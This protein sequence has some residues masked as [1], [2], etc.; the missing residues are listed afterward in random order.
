[1]TTIEQSNYLPELAARIRA[2][3]QA[4]AAALRTS[5]EHGIA[6]GADTL[7]FLSV[8]GMYRAMGYPGRDAANPKFSDHCF[9]GA[10]P[11]SLTD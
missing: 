8:D 4:T 10:Y 9:T 5:V 7:A 1:M 6:A 3:H 2:E 11:T